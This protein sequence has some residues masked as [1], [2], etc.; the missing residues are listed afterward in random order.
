M[1]AILFGSIGVFCDS[2]DLQRRAYNQAFVDVGLDWYWDA[3]LYKNLLLTPGGTARIARF[4]KDYDTGSEIDAAIIHARKAR[5]YAAI[6]EDTQQ[7]LRSGVIRLIKAAKSQG[8]KVGWIT[9]TDYSNLEAIMLRSDGLLTASDFDAITH[10]NTPTFEKPDPSSYFSALKQLGMQAD[11]VVAI[12]DTAVCTR[13]ATRA[14]IT[15]VITPNSYSLDQDYYEA[16]SVVSALGDP[17]APATALHGRPLLDR[18][19]TVT[20]EA[21]QQLTEGATAA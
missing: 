1:K 14:D 13:S 8:I 9:T 17:S 3:P 7:T 19:G 5:L 21:L 4:A 15:C 16:V 12:E 18:Q 2:S 20:L 11:E 10:R 6:L